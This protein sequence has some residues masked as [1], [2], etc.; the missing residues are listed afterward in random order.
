MNKYKSSPNYVA[1][2]ETIFET[3]TNI[4]YTTASLRVMEMSKFQ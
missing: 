1:V 2:L 4:S 3:T